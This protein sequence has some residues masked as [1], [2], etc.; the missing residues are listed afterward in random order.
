MIVIRG[1]THFT[2]AKFL[3]SI[4]KVYEYCDQVHP[5]AFLHD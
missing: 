4:T 5:K 2:G 3:G 1:N